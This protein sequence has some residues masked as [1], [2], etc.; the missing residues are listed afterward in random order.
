MIITLPCHKILGC[1][2]NYA[3]KLI[4]RGLQY[5]F[6]H[7]KDSINLKHGFIRQQ[8]IYI[9]LKILVGHA[10]EI[11]INKHMYIFV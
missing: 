6:G 7:Q 9:T 3:L 2:H 10:N 1:R 8:T 11:C 5:D 4:C